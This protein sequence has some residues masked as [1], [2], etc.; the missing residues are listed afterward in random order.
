MLRGGAQL[1]VQ[2]EL[3][4]IMNMAS[5]QLPLMQQSGENG[6]K[7]AGEDGVSLTEVADNAPYFSAACQPSNR[8]YYAP[9]DVD[10]F[11]APSCRQCGWLFSTCTCCASPDEGSSSKGGKKKREDAPEAGEPM[12]RKGNER[13]PEEEGGKSCGGEEGRDNDDVAAGGGCAPQTRKSA[14][15]NVATSKRVNVPV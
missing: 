9:F 15:R 6:K 4:S 13:P 8:P 3:R 11:L 1:A 10:E 12:A 7:P 2:S 14:R 5:E